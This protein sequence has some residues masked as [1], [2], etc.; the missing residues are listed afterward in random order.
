MQFFFDI[1][2]NDKSHIN[3]KTVEQYTMIIIQFC[4]N[5]MLIIKKNPENTFQKR[6][7]QSLKNFPIY[8]SLE[9]KLKCFK[10]YNKQMFNN[11][12]LYEKIIKDIIK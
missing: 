10:N 4:S 9:F 3:I 12:I 6:L 8:L 2:K 11:T 7:I 1:S 5:N